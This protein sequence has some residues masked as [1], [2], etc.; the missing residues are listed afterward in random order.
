MKKEYEI[1]IEGLSKWNI[2]ITN[3][4]ISTFKKFLEVLI[5]WNEI[6]NITSILSIK[7]IIIK[8]FLDSISSSKFIEYSSQKII[9]IGLGAGFPG[10][11]LKII[12]SDLEVT[13]VE[14]SKKKS[15]ILK[16][17]CKEL[18]IE[19]GIII[20]NDNIEK[21]GRD[22]YFREKYDLSLSRAVASLSTIL[23]YS[24]PLLK[25]GGKAIA[26]KG[27]NC[28]TEVENSVNALT[29]LNAVI[30]ENTEFHLPFSNYARRIII[31]EKTGKT[32]DYF[33]RKTGIPRKKPL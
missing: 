7:E 33:P 17:I 29:K 3:D 2:Q 16:S 30:T 13:F 28:S 25:I 14:S 31:V 8:H 26:Y 12:F 19:N 22:E 4:Q 27:S 32:D 23:E 1:L 24:I 10:L 18:E 9:D 6:T 15:N 11:P 20:I 21:L 5:K